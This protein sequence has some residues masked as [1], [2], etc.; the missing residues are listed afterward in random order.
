MKITFEGVDYEETN[1]LEIL[2]KMLEEK[3]F[4]V[5]FLNLTFTVRPTYI[6]YKGERNKYIGTIILEVVENVSD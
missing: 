5:S 6:T 2:K 1:L 3:E 4:D